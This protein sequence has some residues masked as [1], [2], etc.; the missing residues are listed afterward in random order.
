MKSRLWVAIILCL[1]LS[2]CAVRSG[3]DGFD[4]SFSKMKSYTCNAEITVY[5]N[6]QNSVYNVKQYYMEPDKVRIE[7]LE[8]EFLKDKVSVYSNGSWCINHP[9]IGGKLTYSGSSDA[10]GLADVGIVVKK[11]FCS[12]GA[13][14]S[15]AEINGTEY[16]KI[17]AAIPGDSQFRKTAVLYF[18]DKKYYPV[19]MEILDDKNTRRVEV[20]YS[21]FV[22]NADIESSK[23]EMK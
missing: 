23:F 6:K 8:P 21:N 13:K 11:L 20:K 5:G 14:K 17:Q 1:F 19:Y 7:T 18:D 3:N 2:S 9:Q 15:M 16:I 4:Y 12:S 10:D 22:Y